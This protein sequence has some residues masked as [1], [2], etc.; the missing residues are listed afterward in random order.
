MKFDRSIIRHPCRPQ[1]WAAFSLCA[2]IACGSNSS[3]KQPDDGS[4]ASRSTARTLAFR[5]M[6][7]LAQG[8]AFDA[9]LRQRIWASGREVVGVGHYEQSG[10]GTGRY[11]LEMTIHD[12]DSRQT[13]KQISDGRLAWNRSEIGAAISVRR[14]DLGRIDEY[15]QEMLAAARLKK[16]AAASPGSAPY[17]ATPAIDEDRLPARLLAGGLVELLDRINADYDLRLG[18]GTV[19]GQA[20]WILRGSL[21][22]EEQLRIQQASGRDEIAPLCPVEVRV[23]IA[24][25][26]DANG[27][28]AGLPIRFEFWS[29]P[30]SAPVQRGATGQT[31]AGNG[32]EEPSSVDNQA[33]SDADSATAAASPAAT[34]DVPAGRLISTL[35]IYAMRRIEPSP[36]ERFRFISDDREVTF[37]NDTARYLERLEQP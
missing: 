10:G 37:L 30:Q 18:K 8:D 1:I 33:A 6:E 15:E 24:A 16:L 27:F 5:T 21:R 12:G 4:L 23:A 29:A 17:V 28:G 11:S 7:R 25:D 19:E 36:E 3:A 22:A 34:S 13:M 26:A 32:D 14:I 35:E 9:K 2:L 20:V 31:D